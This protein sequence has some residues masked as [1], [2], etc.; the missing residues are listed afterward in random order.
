MESAERTEVRC[1]Q[2]RV[3]ASTGP[4]VEAC[5]SARTR[6]TESMAERVGRT[7]AESEAPR[8]RSDSVPQPFG[9]SD[10]RQQRLIA[11]LASKGIQRRHRIEHLQQI[12]VACIDGM[13]QH[14]VGAVLQAGQEQQAAA[15][16]QS[17]IAVQRGEG[18]PDTGR[19]STLR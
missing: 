12:E 15:L 18:T 10:A 2:A 14:R 3:S 9:K 5:W 16:R 1:H 13:A 4:P 7:A 19:V 8:W 17:R 11:R 6:A